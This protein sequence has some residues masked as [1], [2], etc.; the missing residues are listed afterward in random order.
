MNASVSKTVLIITD[1]RDLF[2][3]S[4]RFKDTGMDVDQIGKFFDERGWLVRWKK[5]PEIDFRNENYQGQF[6]LY[7][8]SEDRNLFYQSYI[9]DILLGL[10]LQGAILIPDFYCFRAHHNKVFMEILRDITKGEE[11]KNITTKGFGAYEDFA[12]ELR[13]FQSKWVLK[14]SEGCGSMGIKLLQDERSKRKYAKKVSRSLHWLDGIKNIVKSYVWPNYIKQSNNRKKFIIQSYIPGLEHDYKVLVYGDKYYVLLRRIR[15]KDFRASGSG[16]FEYQETIPDGLLNYAE[17]VFN[18]FQIPYLSIDIGFDGK[19]F[20]VFEF[21]FLKFGN[22]TIEKSPFYF[23]RKDQ[24][25]S[26]I[27]GSSN[28]EK[29]FVASVVRYIDEYKL[30]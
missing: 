18:C 6:I 5:F 27:Q 9:E 20:F 19:E 12:P 15:K 26:K 23:V 10:K 21:Q 3:H 13:A 25:W 16:M 1:Y 17:A 29:E 28:L 22:Y 14:P 2:Y 7:Q 11:L 30:V 4:V 24:K 8:S